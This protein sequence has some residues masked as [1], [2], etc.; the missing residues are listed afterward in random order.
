VADDRWLLLLNAGSSSLKYE[1]L[2]ERERSPA[3]GEVGGVG[4]ER[5]AQTLTLAGRTSRAE[6]ACPD[7]AAAL[8]WA[9]AGLR[10]ALPDWAERVAAV[11]HRVV[12]G[13]PRLWQPTSVDD[14]VVAELE[15]Q[16]ELAPLHN[17]PS[18]AALR[19]ARRL[20]PRVPQVAVFDT[21]FHH[22]LPAVARTYALPLDLAE[23]FQIRRYGFHGSSCRYVLGRVAELGI[24]PA[25]RAI[26]CHLGAGASLTAARDGRSVDTSMGFTPLEGLVMGT[27]AGDL[28]PAL[29]LF[30]QRHAGLDADGVERLLERESGLRGLG[31]HG[32]DYAEL[33]R[34]A[35]E[36]DARA[37]LALEIFAYRARKYL[38]AYW[39][40]LGGVDLV[41]F[42]GGIGERSPDAR[43]RILAPMAEVGW[44]L[45]G[46]RN[47]DG[48]AERAISPEGQRPAIW[49]IPTRETLQ[50]GRE[51]R[52]LLAA[53]G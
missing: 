19:A 17:V 8:D 5:A 40:A 7:H 16:A 14:A 21:G 52:A 48:P 39:A 53:S 47:A 13:G 35:G 15:R 23:R 27:R 22:D 34:L 50:I 26:V 12:H 37:D 44:R 33:E 45:D 29:T 9:L 43:R 25:A 1:L 3:R 18:L 4:G 20:L 42:T 41:V 46:E 32:G 6:R 49:T 2:D 30:L 28:D 38:G 51:V 36:G 10:E 24:A 31:G 11:G